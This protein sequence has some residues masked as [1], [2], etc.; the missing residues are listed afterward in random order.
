LRDDQL[1][2]CAKHDEEAAMRAG[3]TWVAV[4]IAAVVVVA[5][6]IVIGIFW[7]Q[8]GASEISA[9]GWLALVFGVVATLAL[10]VGLMALMFISSRRGYD[11]S[12]RGDNQ[13]R[14]R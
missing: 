12:G 14:G 6:A 3:F 2:A 8:L 1:G 4:V 13:G 9:A 10:G 11:G 7:H 5:V